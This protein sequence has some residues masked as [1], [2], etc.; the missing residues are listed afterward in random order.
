[1]KNYFCSCIYKLLAASL[2]LAIWSPLLAI[3]FNEPRR[4]IIPQYA[5]AVYRDLTVL[6]KMYLDVSG[7]RTFLLELGKRPTYFWNQ[8]KMFYLY[9]NQEINI[10]NIVYSTDTSYNPDVL[11]V[12][13]ILVDRGSFLSKNMFFANGSVIEM[14]GS[15]STVIANYKG[16]L[17][18]NLTLSVNVVDSNIFTK[19]LGYTAGS[20]TV[21]PHIDKLY[22]RDVSF[23]SIPFPSPRMMV[24]QRQNPSFYQAQGTS[25]QFT[26]E[27]VSLSGNKGPRNYYGPWELWGPSDKKGVLYPYSGNDPCGGDRVDRCYK[28]NSSG[29]SVD[30]NDDNIFSCVGARNPSSGS[31]DSNQL[32]CYD[33]QVETFP[34]SDPVLYY[35]NNKA[36]FEFKVE[37]IYQVTD[38][39][40][41]LI[42]QS[43]KTRV[44]QVGSEYVTLPISTITATSPNIV[45]GNADFPGVTQYIYIDGSPQILD[46]DFNRTLALG[47]NPCFT[48]CEGKLCDENYA[49]IRNVTTKE[50]KGGSTDSYNYWPAAEGPKQDLFIHTYT[51]GFCPKRK[52]DN[53]Y[54]TYENNYLADTTNNVLLDTTLIPQGSNNW[55]YPK[56][57]LRR[58]VKCSSMNET[59]HYARTYR[60]LTTDY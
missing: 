43:P 34:H 16:D 17:P 49:Y 11:T 31:S 57:C 6:D 38:G 60:P 32:Y 52:N 25:M 27:S 1:M 15:T 24:R 23:N 12:N 41:N 59:Q 50:L 4:V 46:S 51:I 19:A 22:L 47:D 3:D 21:S 10:G 45:W 18:V 44:K 20:G 26:T 40:A 2:F 36:Y 48:I 33:Y 28:Y 54:S 13:N 58:K 29:E 9:Q 55:T 30:D 5:N 39:A 35:N 37:E 14:H 7:D 42:S 56:V 53:S 8:N